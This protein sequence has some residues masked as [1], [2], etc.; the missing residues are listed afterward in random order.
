MIE[1]L[2]LLLGFGTALCAI[3]SLLGLAA[4]WLTAHP[5]AWLTRQLDR[6]FR[7]IGN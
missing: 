6:V 4:D 3:F 5:E 1:N 2:I 7:Q